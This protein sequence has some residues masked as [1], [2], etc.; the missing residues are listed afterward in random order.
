VILLLV[1]SNRGISVLPDW[2]VREVKYSSDYI[3]RPLTQ[4]GITR[5]L[6]AAVRTADAD[7]P[8]MKELVQLARDEAQRLQTA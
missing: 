1:A 6:Y 7:K 8:F 4:A 5:S 3:T 2:V